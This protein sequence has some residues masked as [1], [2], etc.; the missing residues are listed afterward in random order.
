MYRLTGYFIMKLRDY[1]KKHPYTITLRI[2]DIEHRSTTSDGSI[3]LY[4]IRLS[5][6]IAEVQGSILQPDGKPLIMRN[7][8]EVWISEL[9][10]DAVKAFSVGNYGNMKIKLID[11]HLDVSKP[12]K[13]WMELSN[14]SE[15][16]SPSKVWLT[17]ETFA[18]LSN[19]LQNRR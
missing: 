9:N 5:E 8:T 12:R 13:K 15:I 11:V 4:L 3:K 2:K 10:V 19:R 7:V 17:K 16:I 18:T 6:P 14:K 1:L